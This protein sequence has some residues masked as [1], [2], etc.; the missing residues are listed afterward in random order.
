M[1]SNKAARSAFQAPICPRIERRGS[2]PEHNHS[3]AHLKH[4]HFRM[5]TEYEETELAGLPLLVGIRVLD[6]EHKQLVCL[7]MRLRDAEQRKSLEDRTATIRATIDFAKLHFAE[8]EHAME[9]AG[10]PEIEAHRVEHRQMLSRL[11]SVAGSCAVNGVAV[12]DFATELYTWL[13]EHLLKSDALYVEC[14]R[15]LAWPVGAL[16]SA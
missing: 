13:H 8:E 6:E 16:P 14:L 3:P 12:Y 9:V 11:E 10:F 5:T 4:Y 1:G 2:N 7:I 15:T